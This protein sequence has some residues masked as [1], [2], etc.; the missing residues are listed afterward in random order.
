MLVRYVISGGTSASVNIAVLSL[1]YYIFHIYYLLASVISFLVSWFVS[2]FL[3]KFWTFRDRSTKGIHK[4]A[5]MYLVSSLLGLAINTSLLYIFVDY[6]HFYVFLGQVFAGVITA[7][8]TF[9]ISR[10]HVFKNGKISVESVAEAI[11][12]DDI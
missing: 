7:S 12:E 1:L 10:D 9:F 11:V 4:Q 3:Q 5:G 6:L 2:L 8:V